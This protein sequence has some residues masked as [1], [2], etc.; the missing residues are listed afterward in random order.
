MRRKGGAE[1]GLFALTHC[2]G[3]GQATE[4]MIAGEP[5]SVSVSCHIFSFPA[6]LS[7]G[8]CLAL[9]RDD[10][11]R[12]LLSDGSC[13]AHLRDDSSRALLSDG[14]CLALLS[15]DSSRALLPESICPVAAP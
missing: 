11:S 13:L 3:Q 14:S 4:D 8:S 10:S 6:L 7:D 15:D 5:L 1:T 12:A 9:L 2:T